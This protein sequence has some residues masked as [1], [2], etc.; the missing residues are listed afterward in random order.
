MRAGIFSGGA[1]P[2]WSPA[3]VSKFNLLN[4]VNPGCGRSRCSPD[5]EVNIAP[6]RWAEILIAVTA[7]GYCLTRVCSRSGHTIGRGAVKQQSHY[8]QRSHPHLKSIFCKSSK[9]HTRDQLH[10]VICIRRIRWHGAH[11]QAV[12]IVMEIL[13]TD[14]E[15]IAIIFV[16]EKLEGV[17]SADV[18]PYDC[19][20]RWFK[21]LS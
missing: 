3:D 15:K 21:L 5:L 12:A 13:L 18:W 9:L 1:N 17:T 20:C 4:Y 14:P 11:F 7:G 8:F 10:W 2:I 6:G 16:V 19:T